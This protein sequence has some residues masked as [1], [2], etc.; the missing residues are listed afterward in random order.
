MY[1]IICESETLCIWLGTA[2][3]WLCEVE[4]LINFLNL[5]PALPALNISLTCWKE[6]GWGVNIKVFLTDSLVVIDLIFTVSLKI[7]YKMPLKY[8]ALLIF[9]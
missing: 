1:L 4:K 3:S 6:V 9:H 5:L 7:I 2:T 8:S